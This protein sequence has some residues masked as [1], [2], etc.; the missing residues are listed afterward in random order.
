M[1]SGQKE[2][3]RTRAH[4]CAEYHATMTNQI[5][6]SLNFTKL[7][8]LAPKLVAICLILDDV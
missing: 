1:L 4:I 5:E 3:Q 6:E 7:F 2:F 8:K